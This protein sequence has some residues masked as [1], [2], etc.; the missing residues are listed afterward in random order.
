MSVMA[1]SLQQDHRWGAL[2]D[3][4]AAVSWR[5]GAPGSVPGVVLFTQREGS[6]MTSRVGM[7]M[8]AVVVFLAVSAL[9]T[10]GQAQGTMPM[11]TQR[12]EC[13]RNG[14]YWATAAGFCKAGG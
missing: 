1:K 8:A 3:G 10:L 5:T 6:T 13:E 4:A 2:R 11:E 12:R 7:T 9:T 14:G